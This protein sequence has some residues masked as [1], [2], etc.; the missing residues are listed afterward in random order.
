MLFY[1]SVLQEKVIKVCIISSLLTSVIGDIQG[2]IISYY[3]KINK[4]KNHHYLIFLHSDCFIS[5]FFSFFFILLN[6]R[7]FV[8]SKS[9]NVPTV[10]QH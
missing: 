3:I 4:K 10:V 8:S 7:F 2:V 6:F 9:L 1:Q 5:F